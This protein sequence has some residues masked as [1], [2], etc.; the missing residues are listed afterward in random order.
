MLSDERL[1]RM[2]GMDIKS[3]DINTLFDMREIKADMSLPAHERFKEYIEQVKNPYCLRY[4]K[5]SVKLS[6]E[7]GGKS[8]DEAVKEHFINIKNR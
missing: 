7:L 8:L 5:T 4:G 3:A 6:Y 2:S 1:E